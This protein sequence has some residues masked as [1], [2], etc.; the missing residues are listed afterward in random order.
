MRNL[1]QELV[2]IPGPAGA[3]HQ[4]RNRIAEYLRGLG[5]GTRVDALGSL[6]LRK[7]SLRKNGGL[8]V[9]V[10]AHMDEPGIMVTHVDEHGFIR[11]TPVG[12]VRPQTCYGSQVRFVNGTAGVIGIEHLDSMEK[13]PTFDQMFIDVGTA[14]RKDCPVQVGDLAAFDRPFLGLGDHLVGKAIDNRAGA[15]V[16]IETLRQVESSP[17]ELHFVFSVQA[18]VDGQGAVTAAYATDPDLALVVDAT[19][20]GDTPKGNRAGTMLGKGPVI[21][22]RDS[23]QLSNPAWVKWVAT[24][25]ERAGIPY[26]LE[27]LEAGGVEARHIQHTRAGVPSGMLCFPCR[28]LHTPSEMASESDLRHTVRLLV[29]LLSQPIKIA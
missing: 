12:A 2:E 29:E 8:R 14:N 23:T 27:V 19:V 26:Q 11:F 22:L 24:T 5:D 20:T 16:L 10:V 7:G 3:E 6:I 15:A 9:M 1:V 28:Y 21:K 4:V 13:S 25:A 17:H 18:G